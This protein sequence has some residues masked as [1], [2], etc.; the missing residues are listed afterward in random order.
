M[1]VKYNAGDWINHTDGRPPFHV[2]L[3]NTT[4]VNN[5]PNWFEPIEL[6]EDILLKNGWSYLNGRTSGTLTKDTAI[7]MD[8]DFYKGKLQIKSHYEGVEFYREL[9]IYSVHE[10]QNF[11]DSINEELNVQ[12]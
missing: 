11:F 7:K 8:V 6:T 1:R 9:G 3:S 2:T 5:N 12:L 10:L 4:T